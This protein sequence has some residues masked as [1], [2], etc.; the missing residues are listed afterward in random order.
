MGYRPS[1]FY[2]RVCG[3]SLLRLRFRP[4]YL[5]FYFSFLFFFLG[6]GGGVGGVFMDRVE[7]ENKERGQYPA[8]LTQTSLTNKG[9]IT[10]INC[11]AGN[12]QSRAG[13]IVPS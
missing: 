13:K 9:F 5:F 1:S 4:S 6:G 10:W 2:L 12:G 8:L 3:P 7:G 11:H